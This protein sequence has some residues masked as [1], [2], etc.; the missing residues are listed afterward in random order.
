MQN[1]IAQLASA[2]GTRVASGETK[3][4]I[5]VNAADNARLLASTFNNNTITGA[6]DDGIAILMNDSAVAEGVTI[7]TN[8]IVNGGGNGIRLVADGPNAEIH[9][10]NTI[11]GSGINVYNGVNFN[12]GN[13]IKADLLPT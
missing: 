4:G 12:Q 8:T 1:D 11:G 3:S 2:I 5:R 9:A 10:D 7:Q 13:I 6:S